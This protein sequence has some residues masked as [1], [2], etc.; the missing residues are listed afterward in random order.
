M[1]DFR[2]LP[3]PVNIAVLLVSAAIVWGAGT[4][5]ARLVDAIAERTGLGRAFAGFLLLGG[6]TSLPELATVITAAHGGHANLALSSILGSVSTNVLL[7][8]LADAVLGRDA[9]TSVVAHPATLMQGALGILLLG[10]VAAAINIGDVELFGIG[11]WSAALVPLFGLAVWLTSRYENRPTWMVA[12]GAPLP[13][14]AP[15][16]PEELKLD[17]RALV[18]NATAAGVVILVAGYL[19][20]E[21][22]DAIAVQTGIG[23]NMVGFVLV[24]LATSLPEISSMVGAV[25]IHRYELAIGDIFG[26]NLFDLLLIPIADIFFRQGPILAQAGRFEAVAVV[27]GII[28]TSVYVV[29]LLDRRNQTVL[30]MGYDSLAAIVAFGIGIVLLATIA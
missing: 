3:L 7:L 24:G 23:A 15:A 19:L 4:R 28:L 9:L 25:R 18:T 20:A 13:G 11:V 17:L 1:I 29:G 16:E 12:D 5:M 26:T 6:V 2:G 22:G 8:A 27:L 10:V 30:R 14:L 21:S